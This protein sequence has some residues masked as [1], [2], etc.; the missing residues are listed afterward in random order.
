MHAVG[1]YIIIA[2]LAIYLWACV[3]AAALLVWRA[4][5]HVRVWRARDHVRVQYIS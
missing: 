4:R 3:D 1:L 2:E 5:D